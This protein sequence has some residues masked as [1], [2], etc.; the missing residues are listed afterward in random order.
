MEGNRG[1]GVGGFLS[2][3]FLN[4]YISVHSERFH[5]NTTYNRLFDAVAQGEHGASP[6]REVLC[7]GALM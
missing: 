6:C 7:L 3:E 4:C 1:I 5:R 2:S